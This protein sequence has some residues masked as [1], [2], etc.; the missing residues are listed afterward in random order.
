MAQ[1][2]V[3]CVAKILLRI[4]KFAIEARKM[5]NR[6]NFYDVLSIDSKLVTWE[7]C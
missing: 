5:K 2:N 4:F 1:A 6:Q 3:M 7:T